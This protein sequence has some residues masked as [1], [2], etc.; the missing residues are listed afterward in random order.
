MDGRTARLLAN[1]HNGVLTP[2]EQQ[3]FDR[4]LREVLQGTADRLR[5]S[6]GRSRRPDDGTELD[7]ELRRSY[8]RTQRRLDA[9]ARWAQRA[10]PQFT[11]DWDV[12][13]VDTGPSDDEPPG[14]ETEAE[15]SDDVS[16]ATF[17]AEIAQTSDTMEIL[18][19]IAGIQQQ[20]LEHQKSQL[21]S[22][23]RGVFF[24]LAVSVA[25]IVSG[26]A[27][28]VEASPHDRWLILLWT[29]AVC[30]LAGVAYAIVRSVQSRAE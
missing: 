21:L 24:A 18:E 13:A 26:V 28:L 19:Q 9:Q 14:G 10:F 4:A 29:A 7:P 8:Q 5:R 30:V 12:A 22:E 25:V 6:A 1:P 11:G 15:G 17:E 20:Q 3:A 27:P 16:L 2:D 23:T